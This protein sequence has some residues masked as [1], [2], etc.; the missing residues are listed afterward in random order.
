MDLEK[1]ERRLNAINEKFIELGFDFKEDLNELINERPDIAN[2]ILET[3]LKKI[4]Y[5]YNEEQNLIG[6]LLG[7]LHITFILEYGEDDDGE[8]FDIAECRV[9]DINSGDED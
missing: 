8:Y 7:H 4:E 5:F 6:F 9:L 3:K 2:L 1:L